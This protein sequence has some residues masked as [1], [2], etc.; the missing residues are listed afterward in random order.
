M[1][2]SEDDVTSLK[3]HQEVMETCTTWDKSVSLQ[4]DTWKG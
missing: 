3:E 2:V 1:L 4:L